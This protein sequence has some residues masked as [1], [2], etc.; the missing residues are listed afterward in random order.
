MKVKSETYTFLESVERI[1]IELENKLI[2]KQQ[3][4]DLALKITASMDGVRVQS[5]SAKDS[6]GMA[7]SRCV[8][9]EAEIDREVERLVAR[10]KE[11]TQTIEQLYSPIEYDVLHKR[12]IQHKT[13][14]EIA[15]Y[16]NKD[17][18]W[19][20]DTSKRAVGHV[21]AILNKKEKICIG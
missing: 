2:E 15:D 13:L 1:D 6:M 16:Y 4:H 3:W 5:S 9:A 8:D 17:Y 21:Q 20:K 14:Q 10:K 19:A 18:E 11:V 7:V 12:F